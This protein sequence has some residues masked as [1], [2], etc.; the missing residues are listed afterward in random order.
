MMDVV[1]EH[2]RQTFAHDPAY[3][4]H[5]LHALHAG[6]LF[7]RNIIGRT[8]LRDVVARTKRPGPEKP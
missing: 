2:I 4:D 3:R 1:N 6:T 7:T 8:H 5:A